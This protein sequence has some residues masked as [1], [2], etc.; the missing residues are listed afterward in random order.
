MKA[1]N[2][3][4]HEFLHVLGAGHEHIRPDRDDYVTVDWANIVEGK[5]RNFF[6]DK[7]V[8]DP[9]PIRTCNVSAPQGTDQDDCVSGATRT[10]YG[11]PYDY[12][13]VMH[14]FR[15]ALVSPLFEQRSIQES[16]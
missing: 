2:V 10:S 12:Y 5:A 13:S 8:D 4:V 11:F 14:Y 1:I 15:T 3:I 7:W 16:L 9:T 6:K